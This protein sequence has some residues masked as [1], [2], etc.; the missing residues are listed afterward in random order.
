MVKLADKLEAA[1]VTISTRNYNGKHCEAKGCKCSTREGKPYC[2]EH[3]NEHQYVSNLLE[4]V[5]KKAKEEKRVLEKGY[6]AIKPG[7]LTITEVMSHLNQIGTITVHGLS[8]FL[9]IDYLV[10]EQYVI[11]LEKAKKVHVGTTS[12]GS[13]TVRLL[14]G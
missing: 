9:V 6:K 12:R 11:Y 14:R 1:D 2:P 3:V 5:N 7:S 8:R 4:L 10:L 13:K